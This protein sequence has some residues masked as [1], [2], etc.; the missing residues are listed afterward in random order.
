MNEVERMI[1]KIHDAIAVFKE[2]NAETPKYLI[3]DM[4]ARQAIKLT[5]PARKTNPPLVLARYA[6]IPI[7][8]KEDVIIVQRKW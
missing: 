3:L 8:H 7:I 4:E 2:E 1:S 5:H 6:D